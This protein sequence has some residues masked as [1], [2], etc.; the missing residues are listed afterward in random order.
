MKKTILYIITL[1]F[2]VTGGDSAFACGGTK[3][4]LSVGE[5]SA[6]RLKAN[7]TTGYCWHY[8]IENSDIIKIVRDVYKEKKNREG[9]L[10]AGGMRII[11]IKGINE[12]SAAIHLKYCRP[13]QPERIKKT[14]EIF[15]KVEPQLFNSTIPLRQMFFLIMRP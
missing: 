15:I 13:W 14:R 4:V 3:K 2:L 5:T 11:E 10:G 8:T 9:M 12:G 1:M 6:I 7:R